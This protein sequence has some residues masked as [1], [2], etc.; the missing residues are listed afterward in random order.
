[1]KINKRKMISL[2]SVL[3]VLVM[4]FAVGCG[5]SKAPAPSNNGDAADDTVYKFTGGI[6][7]PATHPTAVSMQNLLT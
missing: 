1:M 2:L 5:G 7:P 4:V 3:L 6:Q